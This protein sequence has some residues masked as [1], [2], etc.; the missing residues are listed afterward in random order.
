MCGQRKTIAKFRIGSAPINIELGRYKRIPENQRLCKSC[1]N[2]NPPIE[3]VENEI[4]VLLVCDSYDILRQK[5]YENL[6]DKEQ[7]IALNNNE[8][9]KILLNEPNLV[10]KTAQF[11]VNALDKRSILV[12]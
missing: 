3:C 11:L 12:A 4:H 8:K 2:K 9:L 6:E 1:K 5:L 7:F 10:K